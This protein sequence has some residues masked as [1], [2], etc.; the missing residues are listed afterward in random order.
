MKSGLR[1]CASVN[2]L[3]L[4]ELACSWQALL[5]KAR[6]WI[7]RVAS[8]DNI[9]DLPSREEYRLLTSLGAMWRPPVVAKIAVDG[10]VLVDNSPVTVSC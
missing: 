3:L 10:M 7:E 6:V 9:A 2:V 8:D 4:L 1:L 5:L